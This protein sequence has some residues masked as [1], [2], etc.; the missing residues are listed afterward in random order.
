MNDPGLF[1]D[2]NSFYL[3]IDQ[4]GS[5]RWVYIYYRGAK[6]REMGLGSALTVKLS[7]ARAEAEKARRVGVYAP[8]LSRRGR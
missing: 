8:I 7:E 4:T 2:G 5:K 6:R 3:R 1:A